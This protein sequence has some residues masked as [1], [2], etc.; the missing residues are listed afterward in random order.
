[1]KKLLLILLCV[2][3]IGLGQTAEEYFKK[4]YDY[5]ENGEY[6][7]AIENYT[8]CV[9]LAPENATAFY[10]RGLVYSR[11]LE[12]NEYA[13]ADFTR[14][15]RIDPDYSNAY[16]NRGF[17]YLFLEDYEKAIADFSKASIFF[18]VFGC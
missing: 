12:N 2:P 18:F 9:K 5:E 17:S 7:L 15:I 8:R 13:I 1:M 10:N 3:L 6:K 11:H 14:C 16:Q 4:A